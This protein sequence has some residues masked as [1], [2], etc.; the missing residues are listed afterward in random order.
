MAI[1]RDEAKIDKNFELSDK[2]RD[3][4]VAAGYKVIDTKQ[5]TVVEKA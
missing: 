2:L 3:D 4:I 1:D 5:G